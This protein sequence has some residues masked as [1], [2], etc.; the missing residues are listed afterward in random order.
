[1]T[2]RG[3]HIYLIGLPGSGKSSIGKELAALLG[4]SGY[5]FIDLDDEI[6]KTSGKTIADI[7]TSDGE[8]K[9]REIETNKLLDLSQK[10]FEQHPLVIAAGG[11]TPLRAI[12]RSIM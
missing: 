8:E 4:K 10:H 3:R 9:F 12:N 11:G 1:M 7:F 2:W 6:V 5:E